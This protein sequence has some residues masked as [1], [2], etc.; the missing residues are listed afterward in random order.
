[1]TLA[2][3][4]ISLPINFYFLSSYYQSRPKHFYDS[5]RLM[6]ANNR[7]IIV[8]LAKYL[9]PAI[10]KIFS[11]DLILVA[12]DIAISGLLAPYGR[13]TVMLLNYGLAGSYYF[14]ASALGMSLV[15]VFIFILLIIINYAFKR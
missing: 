4:F 8:A 12:G 6:G 10:L 9:L 2:Y 11:L 3:I 14:G 1:L 7:Q 5:L 13:P 15:L